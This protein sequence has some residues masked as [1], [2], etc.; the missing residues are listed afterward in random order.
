MVNQLVNW[1]AVIKQADDAELIYISDQAVWQT[2]ADLH[3]IDY[4]DADCLIDSCGNVFNLSRQVGNKAKLKPRGETIALNAF[5]G[6]VKAHAAQQG[7]C[8]VAKLYAP[9]IMEAF[10]IVESLQN[11]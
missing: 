5:L 1:P 11:N 8:C 4:D 3:D 6:L 2:D 9:S 7:S 10:K